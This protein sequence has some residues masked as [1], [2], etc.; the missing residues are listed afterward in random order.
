TFHR[1]GKLM[2]TGVSQVE[3]EIKRTLGMGRVDFKNTIYAAQ[4]DLL[5]LLESDPSKRKEWFLRALGID[6]LNK[7]SQGILKD[8]ADAKAGELQMMTG[9]L[10]AL[11]GRQNAEEF[12]VLQGLVAEFTKNLQSLAARHTETSAKKKALDEEIRV[13]DC[14]KTE[15]TKL[16]ER[17]ASGEEEVQALTGQRTQAT[18]KLAGLAK[19]EPEF[20]VLENLVAGIPA[21]KK[22]FE[23]L[24]KQKA[25][26][27]ALS[28]EEK[29]AGQ[30]ITD[31]GKTEKKVNAK[32]LGFDRDA[33]KKQSLITGIARTL[34]LGP[35]ATTAV[36][37][38]AVATCEEKIQHESGT[39]SAQQNQLEAE[40]RKILTDLETIKKAGPEGICPLCR[41]KL[42]T[43][44]TG[45]EKEFEA[46]IQE[47]QE[48][49]V[50][51]LRKVEQIVSEKDTLKSMKLVLAELRTL[52]A[53]LKHRADAEAELREIRNQVA[54]QQKT[55]QALQ[56]KIAD[57]A[58]DETAFAA[59]EREVSALEKTE[60]AYND[61]RTKLAEVSHLK[62]Q[63]SSIDSQVQE[64]IAGLEKIR[65]AIAGLLSNRAAGRSMLLSARSKP[66]QRG[67]PN[68][69]GTRRRRS[70][71]I[72]KPKLRSPA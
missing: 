45:I 41:R 3:T 64:R 12:A 10:E 72:N 16:R 11:I 47:I 4:K 69:S 9:R 26:A 59:T 7:E 15:H 17:L 56:K 40:H 33:A 35:D 52:D 54:A 21:K 42:D 27:D 50:E 32:L 63:V 37:E 60:R 43:H 5:I 57:L 55:H 71:G 22:Q 29:F 2:A 14:Q 38:T 23:T 34:A 68:A 67:P 53:N 25:D 1:E 65:A 46:R 30:K 44:A 24:R 31:L 66:T 19:M 70:P 36:V 20:H 49:A 48:E 61:M 6:Y 18:A 13:L 8:R 51:V 28:M 62:E 39:L 58:F